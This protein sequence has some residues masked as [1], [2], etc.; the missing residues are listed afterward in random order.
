MMRGTIII[1]L[2]LAGLEG[3]ACAQTVEFNRDIRPIFSDRCYTCHGPSSTTR[4]SL[5]RFDTEAGAKQ[6][7]NGHF[8]IAPGSPERSELIRRVTAGNSPVRMPP[9]SAGPALTD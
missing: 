3:L 9:A 7:L 6:A 8:A 2:G 4:R 5:L 1:W